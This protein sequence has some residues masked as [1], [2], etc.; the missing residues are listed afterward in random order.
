MD[1][2]GRGGSD[3]GKP[4]R[5]VVRWGVCAFVLKFGL[6]GFGSVGFEVVSD[7]T[8]FAG[9]PKF[10]AL[11]ADVGRRTKLDARI[12]N[13]LPQVF[14]CFVWPEPK[15]IAGFDSAVKSLGAAAEGAIVCKG[16]RRIVVQGERLC[17]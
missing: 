3:G 15:A 12:D 16:H 1:T 14:L 7:F 2:D 4:G 8:G 17:E 10:S 5:R 11:G 13:P 9:G 6:G